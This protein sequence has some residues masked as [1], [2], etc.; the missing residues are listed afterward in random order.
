MSMREEDFDI[1]AI[2]N[3]ANARNSN[4][5]ETAVT[6]TP[7]KLREYAAMMNTLRDFHDG[8]LVTWKC[9]A[10]RNRKNPES[11]VPAIVMRILDQPVIEAGISSGRSDFMEPLDVVIGFIEADGRFCELHV[12]GRRITK[13][14]EKSA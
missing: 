13:Y 14:V 10:L 11:G 7:A 6:P 12:D 3:A 2:I 5:A 4:H 8:D 9:E 1:D